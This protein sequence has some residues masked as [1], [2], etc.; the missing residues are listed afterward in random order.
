MVRLYLAAKF[1]AKDRIKRLRETIHTNK[2]GQVVGTWLD[3]EKD[4]SSERTRRRYAIRDYTE[5]CGSDILILDTFD[6]SATGGRE[7]EYGIAMAAGKRVWLVGPPRN[8]FHAWADRKFKSWGQVMIALRNKA[9]RG[10]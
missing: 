4:S 10:T 8:I 1:T 7:V 2:W 3:E 9:K 5:V 6:E